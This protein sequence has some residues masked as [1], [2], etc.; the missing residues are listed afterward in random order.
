[1]QEQLTVTVKLCVV[2]R[3]ASAVI[4]RCI[5]CQLVLSVRSQY[6]LFTCCLRAVNVVRPPENC[7]CIRIDISRTSD[8]NVCKYG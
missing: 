4:I 8:G 3:V 6:K 7:L 2:G 5:A 1:M